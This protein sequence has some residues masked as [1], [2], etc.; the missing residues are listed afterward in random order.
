MKKLLETKFYELSLDDLLSTLGE[1]MTKNILSSFSCCKNIDVQNFLREKAVLFSE[2]GYAKTYLIY[3]KSEDE[4]FGESK[5]EL[6]GYYS[7]AAKPLTV[8]REYKGKRINSRDWRKLCSLANARSSDKKCIMSS[9]LIGQLGKNFSNENNLLISGSD[10][11]ELALEKVHKV[12]DLIGGKIVHLECED[13]EKL[14]DF[15]LKNGF[16]VMGKRMLDGDE[17]D[18]KGHELVQLYK[19]LD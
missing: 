15:Y 1:D 5:P 11:L 10:L 18:I 7:I 6:V 8:L 9:I 4:K 3:W 17:T 16:V 13:N 19:Y 12:Q 14:I 2:K